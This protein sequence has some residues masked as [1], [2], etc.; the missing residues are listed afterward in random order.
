MLDADEYLHLAIKASQTGDHHASLEHLHKALAQ[1]PSHAGARYFLAAEHAELGLYERACE[2]MQEL[3]LI[4][5]G[6]EIARFQ[7]GLLN[8]QL[9]RKEPAQQ[10]FKEL[11]ESARDESLMAFAA[12]YLHLL[13]ERQHEAIAQLNEGLKVCGNPALKADMSRVLSSLSS[14]PDEVAKESA[15]AAQPIY[16]GAYRSSDELS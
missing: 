8:L 11:A 7:L 15:E 10:V 14:T 3:L 1:A 2:E 12:A 9:D 13:E 6:M 4:A 5:P 16:L